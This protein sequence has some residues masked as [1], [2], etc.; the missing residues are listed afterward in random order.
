MRVNVVPRVSGDAAAAPQ[1][2]PFTRGWN[3]G[4]SAPAPALIL[5]QQPPHNVYR[6]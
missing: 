2:E 1:A 4:I 6:L 5:V 3:M